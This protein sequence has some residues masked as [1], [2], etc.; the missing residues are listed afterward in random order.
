MA[1][2]AAYAVTIGAA[3]KKTDVDGISTNTDY[4]Q[5][6]SNADHDFHVSTGTGK[7]KTIRALAGGTYDV[8]E[9]GTKFR[10]G[11]FSAAVNAGSL[12]SDRGAVVES[13][14]AS[15]RRVEAVTIIV[16]VGQAAVATDQL[17]SVDATFNYSGTST[18][19]TGGF[20]TTATAVTATKAATSA[21]DA[22]A[23]RIFLDTDNNTL[24]VKKTGGSAL[25]VGTELAVGHIQG[26]VNVSSIQRIRA[27]TTVADA[28]FTGSPSSLSLVLAN[29]TGGTVDPFS[30]TSSDGDYFDMIVQG[31]II[32]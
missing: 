7:H 23:N 14:A 3:T 12:Y 21:G 19:L 28:N 15:A 8:G 22:D 31:F 29:S 26:I 30:L 27:Y 24:K 1:Y 4:L 9:S 5:T 13:N 11:Y 6:L 17:Y 25:N 20:H 10:A 18:Y 16:H 2:T 32:L